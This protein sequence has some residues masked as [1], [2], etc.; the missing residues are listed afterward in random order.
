MKRLVL[1]T[2]GVP[3]TERFSYWRTAVGDGLIGVGVERDKDQEKP[4]Q[5]PAHRLSRRRAQRFRVDLA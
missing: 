2:E 3:E 5:R 1:S 4:L